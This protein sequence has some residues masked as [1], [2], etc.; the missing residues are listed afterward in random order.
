MQWVLPVRER[1]GPAVIGRIKKRIGA[2][3]DSQHG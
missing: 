1:L 2:S 3:K